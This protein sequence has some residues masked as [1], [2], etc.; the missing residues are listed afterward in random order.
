MTKF[1]KGIFSTFVG[2]FWW[3]VIGV[4]YFKYISFV[5]PLEVVSHRVLWTIIFLALYIIARGRINLII[6]TLKNK[7]KFILLFFFRTF[8][9][10]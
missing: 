5:N 1:N 10:Y 6:K 8:N 2:S 9:F 7:K 3:G 4:L